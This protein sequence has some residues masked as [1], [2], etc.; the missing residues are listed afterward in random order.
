MESRCK[1]GGQG[2]VDQKK[3]LLYF[4]LIFFSII[5]FILVEAYIFIWLFICVKISVPLECNGN[6]GRDF[7]LSLYILW[8]V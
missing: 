2:K 8:L 1:T 3:Q 4:Y 7:C 6:E 5:D